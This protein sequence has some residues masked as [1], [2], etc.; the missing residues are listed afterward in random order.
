MILN[1]LFISTAEYAAIA[2]A[3][4]ILVFPETMNHAILAAD[5]EILGKIKKLVDIQELVLSARPPDLDSNSPLIRKVSSARAE[6]AAMFTKRTSRLFEVL[7]CNTKHAHFQSL[8]RPSSSISSSVGAN[9]V[10]RMSRTSS[11]L[12]SVSSAVPP[13]CKALQ[14]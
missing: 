5:T 2:C 4:I 1:S 6:V 14:G 3:L 8:R 9:G 13:P 7:S 12:S 11:L 10:A